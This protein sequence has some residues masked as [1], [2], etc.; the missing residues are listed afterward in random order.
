MAITSRK[1]K[2]ILHP[3]K[4][5]LGKGKH[6]TSITIT[7][8][9]KESILRLWQSRIENGNHFTSIA[10]MWRLGAEIERL[11][12]AQGNHGHSIY[13]HNIHGWFKLFCFIA[14][15]YVDLYRNWWTVNWHYWWL[16]QKAI[17]W[18]WKGIEGKLINI[19][20]TNGPWIY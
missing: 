13:M 8:R 6:F 7:S 16:T 19:I 10:I 15:Y 3:W 18:I 4:S 2:I 9:K 1:K 12:H 11:N 5:R 17:A 14:C 20:M